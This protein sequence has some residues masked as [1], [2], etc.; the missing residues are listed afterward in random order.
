[1]TSLNKIDSAFSSLSKGRYLFLLNGGGGRPGPRRGGS[2][3]N[4][5]KL[6]RVNPVL[7]PT[8]GGSQFF[9]AKKKLLHIA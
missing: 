2:L 1:M 8:G 5:Y 4:F 7:F 6:G 3:V 9:L